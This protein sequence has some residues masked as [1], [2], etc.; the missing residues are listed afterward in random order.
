[1]F[2]KLT[3]TTVEIYKLDGLEALHAHH[4]SEEIRYKKEPKKNQID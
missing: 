3:G 1:V 4:P 2:A